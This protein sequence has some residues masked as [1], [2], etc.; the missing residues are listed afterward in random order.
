MVYS[1]ELE[2][3]F[4]W[5]DWELLVYGVVEIEVDEIFV[6][7][8][9]DDKEEDKRWNFRKYCYLKDDKDLLRK[10]KKEK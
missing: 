5:R 2:K 10:R 1:R 8:S 3:W 7:K 6:G 4:S 9:I